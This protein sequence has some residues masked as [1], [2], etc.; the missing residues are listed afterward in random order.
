MKLK[1]SLYVSP[2]INSPIENPIKIFGMSINI[3][4]IQNN[5]IL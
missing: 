1:L 4:L 2:C 3:P 5:N